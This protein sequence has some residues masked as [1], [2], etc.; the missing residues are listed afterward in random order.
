MS[1]QNIGYMAEPTGAGGS[2]LPSYTAARE[3]TMAD[4]PM[5]VMDLLN[6][7]AGVAR[8]RVSSPTGQ[9]RIS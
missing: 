4:A 8:D 5:T 6:S 7:S 9:Y 1:A 3:V 2:H